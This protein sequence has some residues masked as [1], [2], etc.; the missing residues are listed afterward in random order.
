MRSYGDKGGR[1]RTRRSSD[2]RKFSRTADS[3]HPANTAR[4][5]RGGYRL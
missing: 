2:R 3:V 1:G 5:M 4:P